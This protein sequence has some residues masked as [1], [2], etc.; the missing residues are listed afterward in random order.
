MLGL[1]AISSS[2]PITICQ[3]GNACQDGLP[4]VDDD[5]VV[6]PSDPPALSLLQARE[7]CWAD[8]VACMARPFTAKKGA[9]RIE[10]R[11]AEH[12]ARAYR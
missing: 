8:V 11:T 5:L 4:V 2:L 3:K 7:A 10:D 1:S 12:A 9:P 6:T